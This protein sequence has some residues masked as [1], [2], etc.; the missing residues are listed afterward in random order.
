MISKVGFF[1][2]VRLANVSIFRLIPAIC[3]SVFNKLCDIAPEILIGIT[4]DVVV[5]K[6]N[7]IIGQFGISDPF[8]QLYTVAGLTTLFWFF[9]SVFEYLYSVAWHNLAQDVQHTLRLGLYDKIQN[10]DM[11]FVESKTL[12]SLLSVVH[13]DIDHLEMFFAKGCNE[14][15]QLVTNTAVMGILFCFVSPAI[16]LLSVLPIPFVI[17]ISYF[18]RYKI[19]AVHTIVNQASSD[20]R[21]HITSRLRGILTIKSYTTEQSERAVLEMKSNHY[22]VVSEQSNSISSCYIPT[23]R[24]AVLFGFIASLIIGGNYALNGFMS[25]SWYAALV[26]LTQR[27]LWPFAG[28]A[29][30]I[31]QYERFCS[32]ASRV[33]HLYTMRNNIKDGD[34][35]LLPTNLQGALSFHDV[36]FA[37]ANTI[38]SV[39]A[40]LSFVIP[41]RK[42][43]AFVGASGSGKS[44]IAKLLLRLYDVIDGSICLDGIDINSYKM[45]DLRKAIAFVSQEPYIIH[46][47]IKDNI[48]YGSENVSMDEIIRA[49]KVA[50]L[51]DF[52]MQL[53]DG[54]K[55]P[56]SEQGSNLAGGQKQRIAIAR[57]V[58]KNAPII[59]FDE[60]T[61]AL[62]NETEA[63]LQVSM[64]QLVHQHTI[65]VI[66]HRLLTVQNADIICVLHNGSIIEFGNHKDLLLQQGTYKRLW[67][68]QQKKPYI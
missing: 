59:I 4:I 27:F 50:V 37:Y 49:A 1:T 45:R 63:A 41:A 57:A 25:I 3:Y 56:L 10:A 36:S 66:A 21:S 17:S 29:L 42:T 44:T 51:H 62:D 40:K 33:W 34:Q 31:E 38:H 39:L 35:D 20:L 9:E 52:I 48:S 53:P 64:Q 47:S 6:Q 15:I 18:F 19:S 11:Q 16:A 54:Y 12:G 30:I 8:W 43:I 2:L 23:V 13:D 14:I 7:S 24:M 58:L 65:I 55:T 68:I 26:F 61:S 5:N 46:G 28:L 32:A 67:E 22:K 60:A